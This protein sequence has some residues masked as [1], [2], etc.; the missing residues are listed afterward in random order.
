MSSYWQ[1]ILPFWSTMHRILRRAITVESGQAAAT[2]RRRQASSVTS[3][4]GSSC[5]EIEC[6][7]QSDPAG[8]IPAGSLEVTWEV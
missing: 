2:L 6:Q 3:S 7:K 4:C 8:G 5:P 1:A